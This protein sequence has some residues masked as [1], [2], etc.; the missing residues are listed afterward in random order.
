[1]NINRVIKTAPHN[2]DSINQHST[3]SYT[4]E[5]ES[6]QLNYTNLRILFQ[7]SSVVL[8]GDIRLPQADC[9]QDHD[10]EFFKTLSYLPENTLF[11]VLQ[12]I[13]GA[14]MFLI[15]EVETGTFRL[16]SDRNGHFKLYFAET[17]TGFK[18]SSDLSHFK[19][20]EN[21][22]A[23]ICEYL[24][25]R[26]NNTEY[27]YYGNVV[28]IFNGEYVI[29]KNNKIIIKSRY[30]NVFWGETFIKAWQ[31]AELKSVLIAAISDKLDRSK[32]TYV[33]LSGGVDSALLLALTKEI[34]P[35]V[36]AITPN[37]VQ[38][39]NP[40]LNRAIQ[41]AQKLSVPHEILQIDDNE[42]LQLFDDTTLCLKQ[43]PRHQ[44]SLT[45][46]RMLRSISKPSNIIY[47]EAADSL[48]GSSAVKRYQLRQS[49]IQTVKRIPKRIKNGLLKII[50][51]SSNLSALLK[52]T[53]LSCL[54]GF[55]KLDNPLHFEKM[56]GIAD[57]TILESDF[58]RRYKMIRSDFEQL[59][60]EDLLSIFKQWLLDTDVT[61]HMFETGTISMRF[62][63]NL[64]TP[65]LNVSVLNCAKQLSKSD[66][67]GSSHVKPLLR[68][69]GA[70]FY[71]R[72]WMYLP[73]LGF[74][75]PH[76]SWLENELRD[77]TQEAKAYFGVT[78]CQTNHELDWT[79]AGLYC[80]T[81]KLGLNISIGT[82]LTNG[83]FNGTKSKSTNR[84]DE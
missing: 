43:A 55:N 83:R 18:L 35:D 51:T 42:I 17:A 60:Q 64:V 73:K 37:H 72:D 45:I 75:V 56:L 3:W 38:H 4:I 79:L 32:P 84:H 69:L 58:L 82:R 50:P 10:P 7:D 25:Y 36:I 54:L 22:T 53:P 66:Y 70:E 68:E 67:F 62:N 77:R 13:D 39:P 33:L 30:N 78:E 16:I 23:A 74:P 80:L 6:D 47:G 65:F 52:E 71:P 59:S 15:Y 41:F 19:G 14:F 27:S 81:E 2:D 31:P 63:H 48:F 46:Y 28:Q 61:N 34:V 29:I 40:E 11:S 76:Q 12:K 21:S 26:W 1:M 57:F 24:N 20:F 8:L 44:S 5:L 9:Y 49:R